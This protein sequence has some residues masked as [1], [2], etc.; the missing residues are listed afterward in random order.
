MTRSA[1]YA[2]GLLL[3]AGTARAVG[4]T[5]RPAYV[6]RADNAHGVHLGQR[7]GPLTV[8]CPAGALVVGAPAQT[9]LI[10]FATESDCWACQAHIAGMEA[11]Y[12]SGAVSVTNAVVFWTPRGERRDP[13]VVHARP[14]ARPVCLDDAAA[15]FDRYGIEHTPVTVL[16]RD[17]RVLYMHDRP[18]A[19]VTAQSK[20]VSD[21]QV[22]GVA[23]VTMNRCGSGGSSCTAKFESPYRMRW[24]TMMISPAARRYFTARAVLSLA[25]IAQPCCSSTAAHPTLALSSSIWSWSISLPCA[26]RRHPSWFELILLAASATHP[27]GR[28]AERLQGRPGPPGRRRFPCGR[29][30]ASGT[31]LTDF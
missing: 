13:R 10:T 26:A 25:S 6:S 24:M 11:I 30:G 16:L 28:E 17:G 21:L 19:S 12:Q 9:Q 27:K 2:T 7:M 3:L 1:W 31:R 20:V 18:L 14:N 4:A 15:L 22:Y 23:A 29:A 8:Q 5:R